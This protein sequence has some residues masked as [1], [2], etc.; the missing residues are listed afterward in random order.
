MDLHEFIDRYA[1]GHR[2]QDLINV[3]PASSRVYQRLRNEGQS[4]S[5]IATV[6]W[7]AFIASEAFERVLKLLRA[8][9]TARTAARTL[10]VPRP[11][12]QRFDLLI[13]DPGL[14]SSTPPAS[15]DIDSNLFSSSEVSIGASRAARDGVPPAIGSDNAAVV[16]EAA[17]NGNQSFG[18]VL[19]PAPRVE[20]LYVPMT[21][22]PVDDGNGMRSTAGVVVECRGQSGIIG[23]TAALHGIGKAS[24]VSVN[25]Q[26]GL[27]V[28]SHPITDSAFVTLLTRPSVTALYTK[29]VM[30]GV[31]PG[32]KQKASFIGVKSGAQKTTITGWDPQIP[33]PS[34]YRQA[35]IYTSRDAQPGDSGSALVT[36]N[37]WIVGFAFERT[38]PGDN[39][40][41]CSWVWADSVLNALNV[42]L[43]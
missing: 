17:S 21:A 36:D 34:P 28:R 15:I 9:P 29:G 35:L 18:V 4:R 8:S 32:W 27:V 7:R 31:P 10:I 43:I 37:H 39:P 16:R 12:L 25:G 33:T 20:R 13:L 3:G 19:A 14:P 24:S 42:R 23:V 30:S 1:S 5:L 26:N 2:G 22:V 11:E 41:Q 6:F 38:L 40:A